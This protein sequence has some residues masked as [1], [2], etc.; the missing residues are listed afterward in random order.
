MPLRT[1]LYRSDGWDHIAKRIGMPEGP[2]NIWKGY[3]YPL[4]LPW[5]PAL[6]SVGP[7]YYNL[8]LTFPTLLL[9]LAAT[10]PEDLDLKEQVG[11]L[12]TDPMERMRL[13]RE[14]KE[15]QK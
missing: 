10:S 15:A 2:L 3:P 9:D 4:N 1:L 6:R 13:F 14:H 12:S 11:A 8:H 5:R 7:D